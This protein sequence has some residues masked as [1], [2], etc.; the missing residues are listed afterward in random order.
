MISKSTKKTLKPLSYPT[1]ILIAWKEAIGG[2]NEIR[3]FLMNSQ[4]KELGVFCFALL[5]DKKSRKWLY[6][7]QF[8]HL[9]ATIE[10]VE[11]KEDALLWLKKNGFELLFHMAR[12]ADSW[13]ESQQW[14]RQKDKLYYAI[15][16]QIEYV[17][18]EIDDR[19]NDPHR[20]TP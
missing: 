20:I 6:N 9:L 17:K 5:N 7:N 19:N 16:L 12:S 10:G 11:G 2:N 18:D 4:Y 3:D 8:A 14:L 13:Q 1:K 15:S